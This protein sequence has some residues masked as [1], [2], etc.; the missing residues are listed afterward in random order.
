MLRP[1]SLGRS[2]A[3]YQ[4]CFD[5]R[6]KLVRNRSNKSISNEESAWYYA[7]KTSAE[8]GDSVRLSAQ[9]RRIAVK[10]SS[11]DGKRLL[12]AI[13]KYSVPSVDIYGNY[14]IS[15]DQMAQPG[16]YPLYSFLA[17]TKGGE[18]GELNGELPLG[19]HP[20]T[21]HAAFEKLQFAL[22]GSGCSKNLK[23]L[24]AHGSQIACGLLLVVL[25]D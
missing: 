6:Y 15:S 2:W 22:V 12:D 21:Q 11:S 14:E 1:G 7:A 16:I 10:V 25:A 23:S 17:S 20:T 24:L 5:R 9:F 4:R 19:E 8:T 18:R 3:V 13:K